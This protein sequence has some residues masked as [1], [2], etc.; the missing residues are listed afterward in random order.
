M[1]E[2][3]GWGVQGTQHTSNNNNVGL[4]TPANM[5][6]NIPPEAVLAS[7]M[8][9]LSLQPTTPEQHTATGRLLARQSAPSSLLEE[10]TTPGRGLQ[11]STM[12]GEITSS[13]TFLQPQSPPCREG[14]AW[15]SPDPQ[16][17]PLPQRVGTPGQSPPSPLRRRVDS[18]GPASVQPG[19]SPPRQTAQTV[20]ARNQMTRPADNLPGRPLPQGNITPSPPAPSS[21]RL[22]ALFLAV[23]EPPDLIFLSPTSRLRRRN[24]SIMV[25]FQPDVDRF[26]EYCC[27]ST[28]KRRPLRHLQFF[29][30]HDLPDPREN[31]PGLIAMDFF[32]CVPPSEA[33]RL[34]FF[35]KK[36]MRQGMTDSWDQNTWIAVYLNNL[37]E[38]R[39]ITPQRML[40]V[41]DCQRRALGTPY[42]GVLPNA[43]RCF[44]NVDPSDFNFGQSD[45]A[46]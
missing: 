36:K 11:Q 10:R 21:E 26:S 13:R 33:S 28:P 35:M 18:P 14:I 41:L 3:R 39:L 7:Y 4:G 2:R 30:T 25:Q 17:L 44:P 42:T 15:Q 6:S 31:A 45:R 34:E 12:R 24:C 37:V 16:L 23:Y 27:I 29:S 20:I 5:D 8:D 43:R 46:L 40:H 1:A 32:A 9:L 22:I 19:P 38:S